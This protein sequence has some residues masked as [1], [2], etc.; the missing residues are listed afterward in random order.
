[1]WTLAFWRHEDR[2]DARLRSDARSRDGGVRQEL[3][4]GVKESPGRA[5]AMET[6]LGIAVK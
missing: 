5:G 6:Y 1:M 3:A 4:T 2:P